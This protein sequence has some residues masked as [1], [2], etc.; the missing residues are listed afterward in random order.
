MESATRAAR[1]LSKHFSHVLIS[2]STIRDCNSTGT[3]AQEHGITNSMISSA[4][5]EVADVGNVRFLCC[6]AEYLR[7]TF[8]IL[9]CGGLFQ[10]ILSGY[11][12]GYTESSR[13]EFVLPV[14]IPPAILC[15][16]VGQ[17]R[18]YQ[19]EKRSN[20]RPIIQE[21]R[22]PVPDVLSSTRNSLVSFTTT[23]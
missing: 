3:E 11:M 5:N 12:W 20:D 19:L 22:A 14:L 18:F 1:Y 23:V 17:Y 6:D 2:K 21:E 10:Y 13:L 8:V 15:Y 7:N 4:E 16:V 9:N